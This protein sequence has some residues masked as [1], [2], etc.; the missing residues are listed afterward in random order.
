MKWFLSHLWI[1]VGNINSEIYAKRKYQFIKPFLDNKM[2]IFEE[3]RALKELAGI[4]TC[5]L[6]STKPLCIRPK[7]KKCVFQVTRQ[8]QI[9]HHW[10]K[11]IFVG[12]SPF[13]HIHFLLIPYKNF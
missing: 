5:F 2:S 12:I 7:I 8:C 6:F 9:F 10:P 13:G 11:R 1:S 4:D 3:Y